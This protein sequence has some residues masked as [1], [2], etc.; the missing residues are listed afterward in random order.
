MATK[1]VMVQ[2]LAER[3]ILC[4]CSLFLLQPRHLRLQNAILFSDVLIFLSFLLYLIPL[5]VALRSTVVGRNSSSLRI[6]QDHITS[7]PGI[8]VARVR[9][10]WTFW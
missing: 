1:R 7:G 9:T 8:C 2:F 10:N 6:H 3:D 5:S 4:Q